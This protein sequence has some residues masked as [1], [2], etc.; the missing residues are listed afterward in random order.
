[1]AAGSAA[2]PRGAARGA[3]CCSPPHCQSHTGVTG[4]AVAVCWRDVGCGVEVLVLNGASS[5]LCRKVAAML[6]RLLS[7]LRPKSLVCASPF[8]RQ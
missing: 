6:C 8:E 5:A 3:G 1:M 7:S 2:R 4:L